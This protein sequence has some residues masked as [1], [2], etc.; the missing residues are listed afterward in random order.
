MFKQGDVKPVVRFLNRSQKCKTH[1]LC[2][3]GVNRGKP[4]NIILPCKSTQKPSSFL[5]VRVCMCGHMLPAT[6][7][8][9]RSTHVNPSPLPDSRTPGLLGAAPCAAAPGAWA[10]R[11]AA[12]GSSASCS[13][14]PR[15]RRWPSAA[16]ARRPWPGGRCRPRRR[17]R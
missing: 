7:P 13:P 3:L 4:L 16:P 15:R 5:C 11:P 10:A 9:Q 17:R 8:S 14:P 1:A 6:F 12:L 2:K